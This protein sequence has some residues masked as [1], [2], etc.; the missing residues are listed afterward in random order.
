[1]RENGLM[2]RSTG[3]REFARFGLT[4]AAL[5]DPLG[6]AGL[7]RTAHAN[8]CRWT[9]HPLAEVISFMFPPSPIGEWRAE[10]RAGARG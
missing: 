2:G 1:M 9:R 6:D 3:E 7:R 8:L 5:H 10:A 4:E